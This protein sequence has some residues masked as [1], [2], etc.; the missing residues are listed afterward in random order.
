[1][2]GSLLLEE[3]TP[4]YLVA[5]L[6]E[7]GDIKCGATLISPRVVLSAASEFSLIEFTEDNVSIDHQIAHVCHLSRLFLR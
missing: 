3:D 7:N 5:L 4:P 2:A 6:E 1:M